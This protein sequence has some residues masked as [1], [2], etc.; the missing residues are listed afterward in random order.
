[1]S[2]EFCLR[3]RIIAYFKSYWDGLIKRRN[4]DVVDAGT[5]KLF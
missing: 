5:G 3:E 4:K 1:M 2:R